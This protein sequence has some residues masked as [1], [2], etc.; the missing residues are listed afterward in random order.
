MK[1]DLSKR[2]KAVINT[3][4]KPKTPSE[5]QRGIGLKRKNNLSST[6]KELLRSKLILCLTPKN[7]CGRLYGLTNRGLRLR[8]KG[9]IHDYAIPKNFNWQLYG[10]VACGKQRL[11]LLKAMD[12]P[13]PLK[14]IKERAQEYDPRISRTNANDVLQ[15]FIRRGLVK[16][17]KSGKRVYF[18]AT[19]IA[20]KIKEQ[21]KKS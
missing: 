21:L 6:I 3:L 12:R 20:Q 5:I 18:K 1:H 8:K 4:N 10:W 17:I 14:H 16:K 19:K 7:K 15:E 11:A 9:G 13:L 2:E